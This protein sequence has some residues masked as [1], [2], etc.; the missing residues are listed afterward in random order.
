MKNVPVFLHIPKNAGTDVLGGCSNLIRRESILSGKNNKLGWNLALRTILVKK[1]EQTV[2]TAIAYDPKHLSNPKFSINPQNQYVS[3]IDI[4]SFLHEMHKIDISS[5]HI[6][7]YGFKFLKTD[8]FKKIFYFLNVNPI[9]FS[10]LRDPF[11]RAY[12]MYN[13]ILSSN[14][15]HEDTHQKIKSKSFYDYLNSY[16]LEDSWLIRSITEIDNNKIIDEEDFKQACNILDLLK[17]DDIKNVDDMLNKVFLQASSISMDFLKNN[18]PKKLE[19][20][21]QTS[22]PEKNK[23]CISLLDEETKTKF[24]YR[25]EYDY[26]IYNRYIK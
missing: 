8:F 11:S 22:F 7:S 20:R 2:F 19:T 13:Y 18:L 26:K 23:I 25:T 1:E 17:I 24:L 6:E 12:S 15:K 21:N 16:E 5:I 9:Y 3:E 4:N 10:I 14:S